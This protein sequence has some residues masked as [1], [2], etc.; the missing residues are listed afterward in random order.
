MA[1]YL[2]AVYCFL[3]SV[4][5]SAGVLQLRFGPDNEFPCNIHATCH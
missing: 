4:F 1:V 5:I 3:I 2:M